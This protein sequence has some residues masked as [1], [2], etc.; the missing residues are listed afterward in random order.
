[1]LLEQRT[2]AVA[3]ILFPLVLGKTNVDL[4]DGNGSVNG[5]FTREEYTCSLEWLVQSLDAQTR[6][7]GY[8]FYEESQPGELESID[9][10]FS[11]DH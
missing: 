5:R 8:T 2:A 7:R 11:A 6:A 9:L 1:M 10:S 3:S 4:V